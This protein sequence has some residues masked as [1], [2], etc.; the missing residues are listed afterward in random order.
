M[1]LMN[2]SEKYGMLSA[3]FSPKKWYAMRAQFELKYNV[4]DL[5]NN[6]IGKIEHDK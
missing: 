4:I 2:G 6:K 5:I 3:R 1:P